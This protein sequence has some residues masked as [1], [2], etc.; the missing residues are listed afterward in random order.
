MVGSVAPP[1]HANRLAGPDP[2]ALTDLRGRVVVLDFWATWC[3]PCRMVMP[4]LDGLHRRYHSQGL[5]VLGISDEARGTIQRHLRANPVGYTVAQDV[6]RTSRSF[7]VRAI[8]TLVVIDRR[9]TVREVY[10]GLNGARM[11][12]L[13]TMIPRLLAEP[14]P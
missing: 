11:R 6:R 7:G 1:F 8:P 10:A 2:S 9:G 14:A 3:G 4:L 13:T 5:T 12:E